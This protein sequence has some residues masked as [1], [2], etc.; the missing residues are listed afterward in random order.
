MIAKNTSA[1]LP[2]WLPSFAP[3]PTGGERKRRYRIFERDDYR[4]QFCDR[5]LLADLDTLLDA[6]IDHLYPK[7]LGGDNSPEN[8]VTACRTCN[9]LKDN[10][11]AETIEEGRAIVAHRRGLVLDQYLREFAEAGKTFLR[12]H[13]PEYVASAVAS[14]AA[15]IV[16]QGATSIG[17]MVDALKVLS[18][19]MTDAAGAV[20]SPPEPVSLPAEDIPLDLEEIQQSTEMAIEGRLP[21]SPRPGRKKAWPAS[22]QGP[23]VAP[24]RAVT[25]QAVEQAEGMLQAGYE[26]KAV[27]MET[28]LGLYAVQAMADNLSDDVPKNDWAPAPEELVSV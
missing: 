13:D 14:H 6:T 9:M 20:T 23:K 24:V 15:A 21:S 5:D 25:A 18:R 11:P 4:C 17:E 26:P 2:S 28:G 12:G 1:A 19:I 10:A 8:L 3:R 7:S 22:H 16:S 27:C